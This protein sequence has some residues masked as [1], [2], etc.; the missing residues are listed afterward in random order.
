MWQC[1]FSVLNKNNEIVEALKK[2]R[3]K[4]YYYPLNHYEK[5]GKHCFVS[6]GIIKGREEDKACFFSDIKALEKAEKGR[7]IELLEYEG[8]FFIAV[9]SLS[10]KEHSRELINVFYN[11]RVIHL[12]PAVIYEDGHEEWEIAAISREDIKKIIKIGKKKV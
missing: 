2:H 10:E 5:T 9:T 8:N 11:P 12:K 3:L 7:K 4:A 6:T 1:R